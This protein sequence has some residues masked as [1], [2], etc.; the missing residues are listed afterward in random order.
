MIITENYFTHIGF[1]RMKVED[2]ILDLLHSFDKECKCIM[3]GKDTCH[4]IYYLKKI[5]HVE[6]VDP[7]TIKQLQDNQIIFH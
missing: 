3:Q 6:V 7:G 2:D 4:H 1:Q 5:K